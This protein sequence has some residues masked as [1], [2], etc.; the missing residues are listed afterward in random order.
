MPPKKTPKRKRVPPEETNTMDIKDDID[1]DKL[2]D[3]IQADAIQEMALIVCESETK[4]SCQIG[5]GY[6]IVLSP[7]DQ[8][9]PYIVIQYSTKEP[10]SC[11]VASTSERY[12]EIADLFFSVPSTTFDGLEKDKSGIDGI[13]GLIDCINMYL[14]VSACF[15]E[16]V[17][18]KQ[19]FALSDILYLMRG[20]G[21]YESHGY[22]NALTQHELDFYRDFCK[23]SGHII[24]KDLAIDESSDLG[25]SVRS[26]FAQ[27]SQSDDALA[28]TISH[29]ASIIFYNLIDPILD[30]RGC[31]HFN[32]ERD[33]QVLF[34]FV[35][36]SP[37]YIKFCQQD[38]DLFD[39]N[40]RIKQKLYIKSNEIE[41]LL[42]EL[43]TEWRDD[44]SQRAS[45]R[46]IAFHFSP[47]LDG[48]AMRREL[49]TGKI[50]K[51]DKQQMYESSLVLADNMPEW[52]FIMITHVS[53]KKQNIF[54]E[55]KCI[56]A[57]KQS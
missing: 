57:H 27:Y 45:G 32:F 55:S 56:T 8:K 34:Q 16:D 42:R 9:K 18:D 14:G 10:Y 53:E 19:K 37:N 11:K 7:D 6:M 44:A 29:I 17:A 26:I 25:Q 22:F 51:T 24:L 35:M 30:P 39:N 50:K 23:K 31:E 49:P 33:L 28:D 41:G 20:Y 46:G 15:V 3:M 38:A 4:F 2:W 40:R 52:K 1:G 36:K 12:A 47:L 21:Y 5:K 54:N 48:T 43:Y 13:F